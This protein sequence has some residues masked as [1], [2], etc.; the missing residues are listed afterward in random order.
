[1]LQPQ[2]VI[3][4]TRLNEE[5]YIHEQTESFSMSAMMMTHNM[6]SRVTLGSR[7]GADASKLR[8][9]AHRAPFVAGQTKSRRPAVVS[10]QAQKVRVVIVHQI[11]CGAAAARSVV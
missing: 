7:A 10:V 11:L 8:S 4:Q 2:D 9:K 5:T 6:T 3:T 1:M